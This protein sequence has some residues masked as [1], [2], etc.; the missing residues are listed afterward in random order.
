[1]STRL[2]SA[3]LAAA[4]L[5]PAM[6]FAQDGDQ[7]EKAAPKK[8]TT[9]AVFNLGGTLS[10]TPAPEDPIFG[11]LGS[12]S[13]REL[14]TRLRKSAKD[15]D[16]AAVVLIMGS[17]GAEMGQL[18]ELRQAINEVGDVKPVY[19]HADSVTTGSYAVMCGATR[20]SM[21]PTGD[22]WVNGLY[23]E[24]MYLRGLLDIVGVE[25]DFLTCGDY[26]SAAETFM[27]TGPSDESKEMSGWLYDSLFAAIKKQ[28]ATGRG[29]DDATVQK[30]IDDGLYSA[31]TAKTAGMIDA[32]ETRE[33]L[34]S[35]IKKEHG[36]G[37]KFDRKYGK[38]SGPD[39]DLNSPFGAMQLWAQ[40]LSGPKTRRSTKDAVAIVHIDGQIMLGTEEVSLL[41]GTS[42]AYSEPIRK[43]LNEVG[44]D[45]RVK[46][47]VLR[48]NSPGG[49][50]TASEIMLQAAMQAQTKKPIIVSMG[51][52]AASGG[53]YVSCRADRVFA[54]EATITGSIGVVAGKLATKKMWNKLGINFHAI[55]RGKRAGL[56]KS[57]GPFADADRDELQGWMDTVYGVFKDHVTTGR[58]SLAKDIDAIAGGR[59]YS[60]T[61]ALELGLI[62]EI[63]T[64][65]DAIAYAV[66]KVEL[67][68]YEIRSYPEP[69]NFL[70]QILGD[71]APNKKKDDR[72]L[73]TDMWSGIQPML[74]SVD[75]V[76]TQMVQEALLQLELLQQERASL[77]M[78]VMRTRF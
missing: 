68:D 34:T 37:I 39:I 28:I 10:D 13:L 21:T 44:A 31:E 73:S 7:A 66:E 9:I 27:R 51:G 3:C 52:V 35:T 47:I 64:L 42:G 22:G 71:V 78:P 59:V 75:P 12:E 76:R 55:E 50:A 40:I 61:Q 72:R 54:N 24:Q 26:K 14:T 62:D 56:L 18:E 17:G 49:S 74:K 65:D 58:K 43:A 60:G 15:D 11:S 38:K 32:V 70:D 16:V 46:V 2:F 19:A 33:M 67:E 69:T 57:S 63:G 30:W 8:P 20:L 6:V 48:V 41:G 25:P 29:V 23:G 1:M 77:V 53:Y 45:P 5:S 36:A 4:L